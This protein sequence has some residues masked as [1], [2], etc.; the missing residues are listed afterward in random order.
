MSCLTSV[1]IKLHLKKEA[2]VI[3]MFKLHQRCSHFLKS[4]LRLIEQTAVVLTISHDILT[5][6]DKLVHTYIQQVHTYQ[7]HHQKLY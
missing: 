3:H 5:G 2:V 4:T 6:K 7:T 1:S